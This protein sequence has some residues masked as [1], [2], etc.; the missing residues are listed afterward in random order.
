[1]WHGHEVL[2]QWGRL[3]NLISLIVY[4][5]VVLNG[6]S[7]RMN[8][9]VTWAIC[10]I[11]VNVHMVDWYVNDICWPGYQCDM[12]M[13][14]NHMICAW[15]NVICYTVWI[16]RECHVFA[17]PEMCDLVTEWMISS[18]LVELCIETYI[19]SCIQYTYGIHTCVMKRRIQ[20]QRI[21]SYHTCKRDCNDFI[22]YLLLN[23]SWKREWFTY[24]KMS[25]N[26]WL[27]RRARMMTAR[28]MITLDS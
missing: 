6:L 4:V 7:V 26:M 10:D 8:M 21:H 16:I 22:I 14:E 1:M 20:S 24:L 28:D 2:A 23:K 27:K 12:Y 17:R 18:W 3:I 9:G 15:L 13:T 5:C 11:L 19:L 25:L